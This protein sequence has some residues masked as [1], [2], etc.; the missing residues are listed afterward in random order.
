MPLHAP[1]QVQVLKQREG[2]ASAHSFVTRPPDE[3]AR[4]AIAQSEPSKVG[5]NRAHLPCGIV[6]AFKNQREVAADH[7]TVA[8]RVPDRFER[9][10][11]R[12]AVGVHEPQNIALRLSRRGSNLAPATALTLHDA[13]AQFRRDGWRAVFTASVSDENLLLSWQRLQRLDR[14]RDDSLFVQR[15]HNNA[16]HVTLRMSGRRS[17]MLRPLLILFAKAPIAG[18]AKTRL[19][20][21][22]TP[23]EAAG[24]HSALLMDTVEMLLRLGNCVGLELSTDVPTDA[25][26]GLALTRSLQIK[27]DLGAR[28]FHALQQGLSA[29]SETVMVLGSDS[30]G[31]P[32]AHLAELLRSSAD[33]TLGPTQDGGFFAIACR[34][35]H[36]EMFSGVRW[37]SEY[38][39][40][41]V[42]R[43]SSACGLTVAIGPSWFDV[44][45]EADLLRLLD[46]PDLQRNTAMW[47][48][49]YRER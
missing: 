48:R 25:W 33:V 14:S 31:L 22:L 8:Q 47:A 39:L 28:L 32:P 49:R 13:N 10:G 9:S 40:A 46:M 18:R 41:D 24:L 30:P 29:G 42:V 7:V 19:C 12:A 23:V 20:P 26:A 27:G 15:W 11:S 36:Q 5:I 45:V 17:K 16:Y 34:A 37:S 44:D 38:T 1:D 4:I 3:N 21:P 2:P 6:F 35:V 43:Q